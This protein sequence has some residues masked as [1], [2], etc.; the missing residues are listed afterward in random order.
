MGIGD[1]I[2]VVSCLGGLM[3]ALPAL[4]IFMNLALIGISDRATSR[5]SRGGIIPFFM[6]LVPII[7]I[8]VPAFILLVAGSVFQ[9]F[10]SLIMLFLLFLGFMGLAV[11][12]RLVGQRL[13]AMNERDE[14]PLFQTVTGTLVL[15][16]G[17]AFPLLGWLVVFPFS[18]VVGTG[19][20]F[21]VMMGSIRR[22]FGG[23]TPTI[24][25]QRPAWQE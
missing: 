14:S 10:G 22:F 11:V 12:G 20:V 24:V 21:M 23:G 8:G 17:I 5:L 16:F 18:L 3:L 9:F 4:L 19:A 25:T 2:L 13:T 1:A 6:G 15:S 7:F